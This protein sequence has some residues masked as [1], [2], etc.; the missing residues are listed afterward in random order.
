MCVERSCS[1]AKTHLATFY[2]LQCHFFARMLV[3]GKNHNSMC[4]LADIFN[5]LGV[6]NEE[7]LKIQIRERSM[8]G[9]GMFSQ[10]TDL[11]VVWIA[12]KRIFRH[13]ADRSLGNSTSSKNYL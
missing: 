3:S 12:F 5:L 9:H 4:S 13:I 2:K 7:G 1:H 11:F 6:G 8:V 10:Q